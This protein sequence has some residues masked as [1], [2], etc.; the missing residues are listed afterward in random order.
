[1]NNNNSQFVM[2]DYSTNNAYSMEIWSLLEHKI[3]SYFKIMKLQ[4][5]IFFLIPPK[6]QHAPSIQKGV[7]LMI[8]RETVEWLTVIGYS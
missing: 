2:K 8:S 1:M 6:N 3:M 5:M 7:Q 4:S